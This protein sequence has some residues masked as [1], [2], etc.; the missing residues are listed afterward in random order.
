MNKILFVF[1]ILFLFVSSQSFGENQ[2]KKEN[3]LNLNIQKQDKWDDRTEI[4]LFRNQMNPIERMAKQ[5]T[6]ANY[7]DSDSI[8]YI[9]PFGKQQ[10]NFKLKIN[11]CS[12]LWLELSWSFK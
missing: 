2:V 11:R 12:F 1:L 7:V 8:E 9:I 3:G 5:L 10:D 6:G 4:I